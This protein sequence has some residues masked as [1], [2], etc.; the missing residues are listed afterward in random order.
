MVNKT[1]TIN[2]DD[3]FFVVDML[4]KRWNDIVLSN[5]QLGV[6]ERANLEKEKDTCYR[7][8]NELYMLSVNYTPKPLTVA[9]LEGAYNSGEKKG[10]HVAE[11]RDYYSFSTLEERFKD[12]LRIAHP[13]LSK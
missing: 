7:L 5:K 10:M 4:N 3:L 12:W 13:S 2:K 11:A 9:D 8:M 6:I 1:I